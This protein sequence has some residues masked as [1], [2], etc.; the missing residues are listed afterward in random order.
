MVLSRPQWSSAVLRG[1]EWNCV[2]LNS[3]EWSCVVLSGSE[4]SLGL[5]SFLDGPKQSLAGPQQSKEVLSVLSSP[6][7]PL[8]VVFQ[9]LQI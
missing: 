7:W 2:V 4:W 5:L 8:V 9:V 6:D 1:P 3:P